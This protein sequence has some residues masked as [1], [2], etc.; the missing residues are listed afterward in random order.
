MLPPEEYIIVYNTI[1]NNINLSHDE[2]VKL[3]TQ[4][5]YDMYQPEIDAMITSIKNGEN[6]D[7]SMLKG[8][9]KISMY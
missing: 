5:Y 8:L 4:K 9:R 1:V 6:I 3:L 7:Y 2:I